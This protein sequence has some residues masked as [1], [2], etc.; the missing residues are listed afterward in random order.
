MIKG[1]ALQIC[2][3]SANNNKCTLKIDASGTVHFLGNTFFHGNVRYVSE[4][5]KTKGKKG[6]KRLGE[7]RSHEQVKL[8]ARLDTEAMNEGEVSSQQSKHKVWWNGE[9]SLLQTAET[10][11]KAPRYHVKIGGSEPSPQGKW[12]TKN[13]KV[14][15]RLES[16]NSLRGQNVYLEMRNQARRDGWGMGMRKDFKLHIGYGALGTFSKKKRH[17]CLTF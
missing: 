8:D 5:G 11:K 1:L 13:G 9:T 7:G 16:Q 2:H 15:L 6:K 3:G 10:A 17:D 14:S 4:N 12:T